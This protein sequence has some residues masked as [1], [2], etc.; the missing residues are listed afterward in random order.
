MFELKV[1]RERRQGY[2]PQRRIRSAQD[3]YEA[4]R[5]THELADREIFTVLVLDGKNNVL[6]FNQVSVGSLTSALVHPREV[7][8]PRSSGTLPRSFS[9]IMY[10]DT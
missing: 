4:F 1:V 3:V 9:F 2:G 6:G 7:F 8:N 5:A 10:R